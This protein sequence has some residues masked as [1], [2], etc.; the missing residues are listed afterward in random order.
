MR[1]EEQFGF[2]CGDCHREVYGVSWEHH[3]GINICKKQCGELYPFCPSCGEPGEFFDYRDADK[4]PCEACG[5]PTVRT[6]RTA[7]DV[8]LCQA[9]W[10]EAS[11]SNKAL[12]KSEP[13]T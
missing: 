6:Q 9:C 3:P 4:R 13:K 11:S 10:D 7:D 1:L 2:E 8:L 5:C 12:C